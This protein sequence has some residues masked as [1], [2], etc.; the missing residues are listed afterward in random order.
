MIRGFVLGGVLFILAFSGYLAHHLGFFQP[1]A[2]AE[3]VR[4][5]YYVLFQNHMGAY[6]KISE[7][8]SSVEA[9]AKA[10]G[11]DCRR[12]FGEYF[13]DPRVVEEDRLRAR[14]GCLS[15]QPYAQA[16]KGL[17]LDTI[18]QQQVLA[19]NFAGS[20]AI[21]PYKV[22]TEVERYRNR[23]RLPGG[24][25]AIEI[26]MIVGDSIATEYLFPLK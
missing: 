24:A 26:Y 17:I 22:Y 1:V 6:Y 20:P 3:A 5:P 9:A 7:T 23:H 15:D 10:A 8:I 18:A 19:A 13:D 4:G 11:L 16:P 2:V 25:H 14:G 12:T 21:G